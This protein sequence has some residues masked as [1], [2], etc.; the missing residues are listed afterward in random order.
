MPCQLRRPSTA[1]A[2]SADKT[3]GVNLNN[4]HGICD[5][6][7]QSINVDIVRILM[8]KQQAVVIP[9]SADESSSERSLTINI[10]K[11]NY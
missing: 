2:V 3:G 1:G 7:S 6:D 10:K 8:I 9:V 11:K 4:I 5:S